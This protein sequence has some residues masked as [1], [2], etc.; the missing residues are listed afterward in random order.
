MDR[1]R[2]LTRPAYICTM[3]KITYTTKNRPRPNPR[4]A[5]PYTI[6]CSQLRMGI[7]YRYRE[8]EHLFAESSLSRFKAARQMMNSASGPYQWTCRMNRGCTQGNPR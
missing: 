5:S 1:L 6:L 8:N 2:P 4:I 7:N 3:A